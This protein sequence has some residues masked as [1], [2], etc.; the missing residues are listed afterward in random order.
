MEHIAALLLVVGCSGDLGD[1]REITPPEA[2]FETMEACDEKI[3]P[4]W[5]ALGES[6]PRVFAKCVFVDPAQPEEDA[7]LN[8]EVTKAGQLEA[9]ITFGSAAVALVQ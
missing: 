8:W 2:V 4:T 6:Q 1:C 9:E 5:K 3:G 7:Q